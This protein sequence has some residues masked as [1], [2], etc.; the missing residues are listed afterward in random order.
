MGREKR[1]QKK[2]EREREREVKRFAGATRMNFNDL[3]FNE[4]HSEKGDFFAEW[5][6]AGT[7]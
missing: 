2:K 3:S 6:M 7:S 1:L 5:F 4:R